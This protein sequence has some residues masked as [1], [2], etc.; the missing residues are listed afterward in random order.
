M[1]SIKI[2]DVLDIIR[3]AK[4]SQRDAGLL[5]NT[6]TESCISDLERKLIKLQAARETIGILVSIFPSGTASWI[7]DHEEKAKT[8]AN[9]KNLLISIDNSVSCLEMKVTQRNLEDTYVASEDPTGTQGRPRKQIGIDQ[10]EA[11]LQLGFSNVEI[12]NLLGMS[13]I[14]SRD[15][16][17]T[18]DVSK[19]LV[20]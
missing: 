7:G 8:M 9:M 18:F 19:S 16:Y 17:S 3:E 6:Q 5:L 13:S 2:E 11:L 1:S 20:I 15:F 14:G 12:A 10:L 4:K